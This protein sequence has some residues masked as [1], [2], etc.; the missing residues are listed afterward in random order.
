MLKFDKETYYK[1]YGTT[2][3]TR[4][5]KD[6]YLREHKDF[7][8]TV[9]S[10]DFDEYRPGGKRRLD[11]GI[12]VIQVQAIARMIDDQEFKKDLADYLVDIEYDEN[13]IQEERNKVIQELFRAEGA[14]DVISGNELTNKVPML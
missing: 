14:I 13:Q 4:T 3:I 10:T 9:V 7:V 2:D 8:D 1:L 12:L 5:D 11:L 6:T